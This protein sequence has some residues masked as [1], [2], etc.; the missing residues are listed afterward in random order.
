MDIE[1]WTSKAWLFIKLVE[2]EVNLYSNV[3]WNHIHS[4]NY[5]SFQDPA[6]TPI[7]II[8]EMKCYIKDNYIKPSIK[9]D[10]CQ[11][12]TFLLNFT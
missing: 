1:L 4:S 3:V 12:K 9:S 5:N 7:S 11:V 2:T 8:N 6:Y 10:W